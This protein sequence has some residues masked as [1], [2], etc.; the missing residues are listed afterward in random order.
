MKRLTAGAI[1]VLSANSL[2]G[3]LV[4]GGFETGD[5]TGW[6]TTGATDF[7]SVAGGTSGN[8]NFYPVPH[9]GTYAASYGPETEAYL[10]QSLATVAGQTYT[11]SFWLAGGQQ[12]NFT[13]GSYFKAEAGGNTLFE[14][15]NRS[16]FTDPSFPDPFAY[17]LFSTMFTAIGPATALKF[18][19]QH[20]TDYYFFD[21][22][23][24]Q[25]VPVPAT[26][27][28]VAIGLAGATVHRSRRRR[29]P[30]RE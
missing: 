15:D 1:L 7:V 24:V 19:F 26:L 5:F 25:S 12:E 17:M 6:T 4:N 13:A 30:V 20:E 18:T 8:P 10:E 22:V 23:S 27:W 14:I 11:L 28:L 3:L 16:G 21:D 29:L 2:A 9:T